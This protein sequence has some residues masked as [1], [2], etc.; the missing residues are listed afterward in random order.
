MIELHRKSSEP[1]PSSWKLDKFHL[2]SVSETHHIILACLFLAAAFTIYSLLNV[3]IISLLEASRWLVIFGLTGFFTSYLIRNRFG[4]SL[5]DGLYYSVF[6]VAPLAMAFFLIVNASCSETTT[7]IHQIIDIEFEGS[8]FTYVLRDSTYQDVW[9]IRNMAD[10]PKTASPVLKLIVCNGV[11][12]Y[13]V[14]RD[15]EVL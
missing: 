13:K 1:A 2:E 11:F 15:K 6:G 14:I 7:E 8:G 9:R 3:T 4:L 5:L 10:G 12:G